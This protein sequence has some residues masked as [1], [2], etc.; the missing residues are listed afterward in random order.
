LE[1]QVRF[2]LALD[3]ELFAVD[4]EEFVEA[5]FGFALEVE[6][7]FDGGGEAVLVGVLGA[8]LFAFV[9]LGAGGFV[10]VAVVVDGVDVL[11]LHDVG[12]DFVDLVLNGFHARIVLA[13]VGKSRVAGGGNA[14]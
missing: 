9:G 11:P 4:G 8:F 1:E 6:A 10:V 5:G 14:K 13:G 3:F 7:G 12:D 2:E